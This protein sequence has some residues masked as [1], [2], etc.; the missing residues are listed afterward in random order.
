MTVAVDGRAL[1]RPHVRG[2]GRY[3]L[4][5]LR[6]DAAQ[7]IRWIVFGDRPDLPIWI[8]ESDGIS[9]RAFE[10]RGD[11]VHAW[12]QIALPLRA[13]RAG[14]DVLFCPA[15]EAP[16][17][18]PLP[19]V[20]TL[21]DVIPWITRDEGSGPGLYRDR[22]LPRAFAAAAAMMSP[23]RSSVDAI[24]NR[25][26]ALS[27]KLTMVPN[28]VEE[29]FLAATPGAL[30]AS[31]H[32][33]GVRQPYVMYVGGEIARK[34]FDWAIQVWRDAT[35]GQV[36]LVACGINAHAQ[37]SLRSALPSDLRGSVHFVGYVSDAD[38]AAMYVNAALVLYPTAYE[39][40]GLP[41]V[42]AQACGTP[43]LFSAV[44]S[45][46][47]LQGPGACILP[48]NDKD[49]WVQ[50]CRLHI[51]QRTSRVVQDERAR[52]WAAQFS[53]RSTA[54]RVIAVLQAA[55]RCGVAA[56]QLH[57]SVL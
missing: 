4:R 52:A 51:R 16:M 27:Q 55:A 42:E 24:V 40:F 2:I 30:P 29:L 21:H 49:A 10:C 12:E 9:V 47:E 23:S 5:I 25:W 44:T 33:A 39:G 45:L 31:L 41:A 1:N 36:P 32:A 28:G 48:A 54:A 50:A 35:Q 22:V 6:S 13:R 15:G 34:R 18:Q 20:I 46:S 26:P 53:W 17:W 57:E 43:V 56:S 7:E 11:R 14:A 3:L 37:E 8:D 38:L 19:T